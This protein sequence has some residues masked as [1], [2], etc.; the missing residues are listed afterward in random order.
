MD[1]VAGENIF[2]IVSVKIKN[3]KPHNLELLN[4][5]GF[6]KNLSKKLEE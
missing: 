6:H 3:F 2:K 1:L 5:S 4:L